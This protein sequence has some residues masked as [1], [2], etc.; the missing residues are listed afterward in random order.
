MEGA[1]RILLPVYLV[2]LPN[3]LKGEGLGGRA[4]RPPLIRPLSLF[5]GILVRQRARV[6]GVGRC[7]HGV[8]FPLR[9]SLDVEGRVRLPEQV[10]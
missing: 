5:V 1:T 3:S 10:R 2:S 6:W 9:S 4:A 7:R 8:F